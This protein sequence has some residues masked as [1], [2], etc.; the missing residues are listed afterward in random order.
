MRIFGSFDRC[1]DDSVTP[2]IKIANRDFS[3]PMSKGGRISPAIFLSLFAE[4]FVYY[5]I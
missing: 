5:R 1:N 2:E 4:A 3:I